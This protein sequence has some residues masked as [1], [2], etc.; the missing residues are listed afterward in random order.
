MKLGNRSDTDEN[1]TRRKPRGSNWTRRRPHSTRV[2]GVDYKLGDCMA[3]DQLEVFA[4]QLETL[5]LRQGA[6]SHDLARLCADLKSLL[7]QYHNIFTERGLELPDVYDLVCTKDEYRALYDACQ[8]LVRS[9]ATT[10]A[11][12]RRSIKAA[13]V[14]FFGA[15]AAAVIWWH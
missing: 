1:N 6:T 7:S 3:N 5:R 10:R 13:A 4:V 14:A 15:V 9:A 12:R 8:T 11:R 2:T